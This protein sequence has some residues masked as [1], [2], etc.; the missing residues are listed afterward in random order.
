MAHVSFPSPARRR[1]PDRRCGRV[2]RRRPT[3]RHAA[4]NAGVSAEA[5]SASHD[6]DD[7]S[8][9]RRVQSRSRQ[10]RRATPAPGC[11]RDG[12]GQL[13]RTF[14]DT[15]GTRKVDTYSYYLDGRKSTARSTPTATGKP[16]QYPLVR[17][18][19]HAVGRRLE[20]RR[21]HRRLEA[22]LRRRSQPG[23]PAGRRD[24]QREPAAG[25]LISEAEIK[26]LDLP[27]AEA[28][29]I[30]RRRRQDPRP[31]SR[32]T[33]AKTAVSDTTRWL[34]LETPAAAVHPGRDDRRQS[35]T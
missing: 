26:A 32:T 12:R 15:K 8:R 31:S 20:R 28:T 7:R 11:S 30:A 33:V 27:A 22:D 35:S 9:D 3:E 23:S 25:A 17:L 21:R 4:T 5:G 29:R 13:L 14:A 24:P 10:G 6:A 18:G 34:H 16:D 2:G 1:L 19:R